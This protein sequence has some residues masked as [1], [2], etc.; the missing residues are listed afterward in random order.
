M[1][2]ITP[3]EVGITRLS[4]VFLRGHLKLIAAGMQPRG[5]KTD[6]LRAAEKI[7][8]QKYKRGEYQKAADDITTWLAENT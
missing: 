5:R 4:A 2:I 3:E 8:G 7:T 1:T 6:M